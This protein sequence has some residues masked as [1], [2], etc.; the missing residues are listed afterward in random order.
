VCANKTQE[1]QRTK[2]QTTKHSAPLRSNGFSQRNVPSHT[3]RIA[4][5]RGALD[6]MRDKAVVM[7]RMEEYAK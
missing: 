4:K 2:H 1:Q 6:N 5:N 3:Q 7:A